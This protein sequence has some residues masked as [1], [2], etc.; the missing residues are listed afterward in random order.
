V[1]ESFTAEMAAIVARQ[2]RER[3]IEL[4]EQNLFTCGTP[5]MD[6]NQLIALINGENK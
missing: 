4:L 2:E 6:R 3:I 1:S 5:V